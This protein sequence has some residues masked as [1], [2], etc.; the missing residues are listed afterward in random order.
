MGFS[1]LFHAVLVTSAPWS[2]VF[3]RVGVG[4]VFLWEGL[5]KFRDADGLGAGRFRRLGLPSPGGLA[6]LVGALQ[7]VCG[8]LILLGLATRAAA[9]PMLA[10]M[11]GATWTVLRPIARAEG[12]WKALHDARAVWALAF[13]LMFLLAAGG[14]AFSLDAAVTAPHDAGDGSSTVT[15][16]KRR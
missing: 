11:A 4:A 7:V 6:A 13:G 10:L 8:T 15:V 16:P 3:V 1:D 14:G 9:V 5:L 12:A 2:V